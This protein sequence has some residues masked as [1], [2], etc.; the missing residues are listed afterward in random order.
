MQD[1]LRVIHIEVEGVYSDWP[2][3]KRTLTINPTSLSSS[4]A[5]C[6]D[7]LK[8]DTYDDTRNATM[9]T[10]FLFGLGQYFNTLDVQDETSKINVMP[11]FLQGT[12]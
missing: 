6:V 11:I 8:P 1:E 9:M 12:V 5:H 4:D 2:M 10:K 7:V 3:H